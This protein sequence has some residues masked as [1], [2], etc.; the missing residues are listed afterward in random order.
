MVALS[1]YR[2]RERERERERKGEE[3]RR[4]PFKIHARVQAL[5]EGGGPTIIF[6]KGDQIGY[7]LVR[8]PS[9]CDDCSHTS[10]YLLFQK[11]IRDG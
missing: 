1:W 10:H 4:F 11:E 2:G 6:S 9:D 3:G 8:E 5:S 7:L